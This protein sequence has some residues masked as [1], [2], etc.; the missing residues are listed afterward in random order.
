MKRVLFVRLIWS[1]WYTLCCE[2]KANLKT[3]Q[4]LVPKTEGTITVKF[5]SKILFGSYFK[6]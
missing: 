1:I 5:T 4:D 2:I 6:L 3:F